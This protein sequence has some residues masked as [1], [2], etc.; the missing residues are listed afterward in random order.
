[1]LLKVWISKARN[2]AFYFKTKLLLNRA[3][4]R[5]K[6]ELLEEELICVGVLAQNMPSSSGLNNKH[7]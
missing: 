6:T 5:Q 3:V 1:L 7:L 2:S 4:N